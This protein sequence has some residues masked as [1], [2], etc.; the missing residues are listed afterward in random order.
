M[1]NSHNNLLC[2]Y[3]CN[4]PKPT[5]AAQCTRSSIALQCTILHVVHNSGGSRI[6]LVGEGIAAECCF[7]PTVRSK[8]NST[9][10]C[11]EFVNLLVQEFFD[12]LGKLEHWPLKVLQQ[13]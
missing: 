12:I 4:A 3:Y 6:R 11:A 5:V 2:S 8:I 7:C 10:C 13:K 9:Q 1:D